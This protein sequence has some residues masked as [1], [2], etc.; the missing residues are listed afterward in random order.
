MK[1]PPFFQGAGMNTNMQH[2][3]EEINRLTAELAD[4]QAALP[5]HSVRPHQFMAIE[6]LEEELDRKQKILNA[7]EKSGGDRSREEDD[8]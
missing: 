6:A 7:R 4:R 3:H 5:A 1:K 8:G 2:L